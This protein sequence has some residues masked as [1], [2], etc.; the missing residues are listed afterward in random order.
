M[1]ERMPDWLL[2]IVYLV[3]P[4]IVLIKG[5]PWIGVVVQVLI[6]IPV[7]VAI[8]F[9]GTAILRQLARPF[10]YSR[11][12]VEYGHRASGFLIFLLLVQIIV[13]MAPFKKR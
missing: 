13:G 11:Q 5:M 10:P 12:L 1:I 8:H 6:A 2:A 7:T 3:T 9:A 4:W